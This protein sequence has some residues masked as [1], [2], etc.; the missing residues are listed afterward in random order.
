LDNQKYKD[1]NFEIKIISADSF[2][3]LTYD[4]KDNCVINLGQDSKYEKI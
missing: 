3:V 2:Y 1:K 4:P